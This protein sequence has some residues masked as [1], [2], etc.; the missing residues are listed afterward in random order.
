MMEHVE[1]KTA[2][3]LEAATATATAETIDPAVTMT[4]ATAETID[5]AVTMTFTFGD[6]A[7]NGPPP[8]EKI[9]GRLGALDRGLSLT[10]LQG[11]YRVCKARALRPVIVDLRALLDDDDA[12]AAE[13]AYLLLV[14]GWLPRADADALYREQAGLQWDSRAKMRGLVKNKVARHNLCFAD[15][16]QEP[17]YDAGKGRVYHFRDVPR[18][19]AVQQQLPTYFGEKAA[20][21]P[22]E[23]N[24][25][26]RMHGGARGCGIGF[27]G[28]AERVVVIA[29]RVGAMR[30][31]H[32][33]W[34]RH[35][36]PVGRRGVV[37]IPHGAM[38]AMEHKATGNDWKR[39]SGGVLTL[40]HAAGDAKYL[41]LSE[42]RD[43]VDMRSL[44][45][46]G[47]GSGGG[48][49]GDG[50]D[51]TDSRRSRKRVRCE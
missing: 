46:V 4:T 39:R 8:M 26:Y 38:Y 16:S 20:E 19:L 10:D 11:A 6:V 1:V 12:A 29:L 3:K 32:Y 17:D 9:V 27:H 23:G 14:D 13:P 18:L 22:G 30:Q 34:Y 48:G 44:P 7:E 2:E 21:L 28:D 47:D 36:G 45:D 31:L 24:K 51:D 5:P 49:E 25:Y 43:T 50:V 41:R 33:Q 40:R 37:A 42:A 35:G 15:R